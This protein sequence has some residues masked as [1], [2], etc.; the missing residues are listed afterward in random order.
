VLLI[1]FISLIGGHIW[2]YKKNVRQLHISQESKSIEN[3][4][5]IGSFLNSGPTFHRYQ[6]FVADCFDPEHQISSKRITDVHIKCC[7]HSRISEYLKQDKQ[8]NFARN[9]WTFIELVFEPTP[10]HYIIEVCSELLCNT[11]PSHPEQ[12]DRSLNM[13][14]TQFNNENLYGITPAL[15]LEYRERVRNV[16]FHG[17]DLY[18]K[19]AF[20]M[21]CVS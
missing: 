6:S 9:K 14:K 13:S 1:L 8:N 12:F 5:E 15:Q 21:V 16:F 3:E 2:C 17:Y 11:S 19:N 7:D 18:M 20:P 4:H 10:C